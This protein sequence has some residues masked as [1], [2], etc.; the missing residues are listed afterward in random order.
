[1][2]YP[3]RVQLRKLRGIGNYQF[4]KGIGTVLF[5]QKVK[6]ECSRKTG[7][8]RHIY[9]HEELIATLRPKDGFLALTPAGANKILSRIRN[10]PNLV[11]V[12]SS[13]RDEIKAGGDVFAKHVVRA[14]D[15]LRPGEEAVVADEERRLLGVGSAV[16]TGREMRAFKRGVAVNLRRGVDEAANESVDYSNTVE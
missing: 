2:K 9:D 4:G 6:I 16:L 14:D 5:H 7:R 1:L 10:P 15:E 11:L 3:S 12:D 8:I 13:V